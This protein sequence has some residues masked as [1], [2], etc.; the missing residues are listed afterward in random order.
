MGLENVQC[1]TPLP[2]VTIV[3]AMVYAIEQPP[4][5]DVNEIV[6]RPAGQAF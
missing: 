5:V 4:E 3:S 6:V 1:R 2:A